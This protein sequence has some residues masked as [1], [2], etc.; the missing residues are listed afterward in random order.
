M[1]VV[2][3]EELGME[4]RVGLVSMGDPWHGQDLVEMSALL[5]G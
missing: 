4:G 1:L 5:M 2:S 3:A